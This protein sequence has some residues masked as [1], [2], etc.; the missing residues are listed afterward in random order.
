MGIKIF[1]IKIFSRISIV[2]ELLSFLW[3]NKLWWMIPMV[4][5]F[6]LLGIF[7]IF[8]Q[9]AAVVPFIYTLF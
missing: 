7:I 3:Q 4:L 8:T 5:V 2:R 6:L 1:I 9:S